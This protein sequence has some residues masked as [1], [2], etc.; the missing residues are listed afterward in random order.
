M[1]GLRAKL[2]VVPRNKVAKLCLILRQEQ[3]HRVIACSWLQH[4]WLRHRSTSGQ[5]LKLCMPTCRECP[6]HQS[7]GIA[8]SGILQLVEVVAYVITNV[9]WKYFSVWFPPPCRAFSCWIILPLDSTKCLLLA[10]SSSESLATYIRN[11]TCGIR[12]KINKQTIYQTNPTHFRDWVCPKFPISRVPPVFRPPSRAAAALRADWAAQLL[13]AWKTGWK[14]AWKRILNF[15]PPRF[16]ACA[17]P[18]LSFYKKG[19]KLFVLL[20]QSQ[21]SKEH[22]ID[23]AFRNL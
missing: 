6:Q 7:S 5:A 19:W 17:L 20:K 16:C 13:E 21:G 8:L 1:Q 3:T 15:D 10:A 18:Y 4:L 22:W 23:S 14:E 2:S 9:F 12:Q 11:K